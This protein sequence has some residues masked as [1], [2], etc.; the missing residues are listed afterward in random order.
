MGSTF[1]L[2]VVDGLLTTWTESFY[3]LKDSVE[4]ENNYQVVQPGVWSSYGEL[5]VGEVNGKFCICCPSLSF[6]LDGLEGNMHEEFHEIRRWE[7]AWQLGVSKPGERTVRGFGEYGYIY[8]P[9]ASHY[10]L[11]FNEELNFIADGGEPWRG[12]NAYRWEEVY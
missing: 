9:Q 12:P 10:E 7:T 11:D 8:W 4:C 5:V 2:S 3:V 6:R 1:K